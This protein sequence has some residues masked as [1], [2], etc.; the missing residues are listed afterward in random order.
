M[1][2]IPSTSHAPIM[3]Y[4]LDSSAD[5]P[6]GESAQPA[7]LQAAWQQLN[8]SAILDIEANASTLTKLA[9]LD[10]GALS[11]HLAQRA[12]Q[13]QSQIAAFRWGI[14]GALGPHVLSAQK[15]DVID[16]FE[17]IMTEENEG[18][19]KRNGDILGKYADF[20]S[21]LGALMVKINAAVT[22]AED[23]KSNLNGKRILEAIQEFSRK[24]S[25]DRKTIGSFKK[26]DDAVAFQERFRGNTTEI[27]WNNTTQKYDVNF[28]INGLDPILDAIT[29]DPASAKYLQLMLSTGGNLTSATAINKLR[30]D[31]VTSPTVQALSL[32]TS[33]VQK[34]FQTDLDLQINEL[35]RSISQFD[36][37]VKLFSSM[38]AALTD[39][40][41]TFL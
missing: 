6:T 33:D 19:V 14:S 11:L 23:G 5:V 17:K 39:T 31:E 37:L 8:Q 34:T 38:V 35:S 16:S 15:V 9:T 30:K 32:A 3:P 13:R 22:A 24:F 10:S 1:T 36:N 20:M 40:Y 28:R 12:T 25:G 21:E 41:K 2:S 27:K 29:S 4:P 7:N 26:N 18:T